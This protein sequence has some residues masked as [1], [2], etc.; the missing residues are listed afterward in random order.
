M[1]L[2][3]PFS[4]TWKLWASQRQRLSRACYP[5]GPTPLRNVHQMSQV[6][7]EAFLSAQWPTASIVLHFIFLCALQVHTQDSAFAK[8]KL[9]GTSSSSHLI[10]AGQGTL[11]KAELMASTNSSS[12]MLTSSAAW[13]CD[14]DH[15][16]EL[17]VSESCIKRSA[18]AWCDACLQP[19]HTAARVSVRPV[20][21][22]LKAR[23]TETALPN[24]GVFK[25]WRLSKGS[26]AFWEQSPVN[27]ANR[28]ESS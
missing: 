12:C 6:P 23:A 10:T 13:A 14:V 21:T 24:L 8:R 15:T 28:K 16:K 4:L 27:Q 2:R 3:L 1:E 18:S 7:W 20:G 26:N 17:R 25:Q 9:H 11:T 19:Q 5:E 22:V